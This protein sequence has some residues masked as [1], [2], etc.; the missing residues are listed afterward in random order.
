MQ[1]ARPRLQIIPSAAMG[2]LLTGEQHSDTSKAA[3]DPRTSAQLQ[4]VKNNPDLN[5]DFHG[6]G[7]CESTLA[8]AERLSMGTELA[9]QLGWSRK[10]IHG[11]RACESTWLEQKDHPWVQSCILTAYVED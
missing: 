2:T 7:A 4:L 3:T 10:T 11:Y 9:C 6:Y 8:G 5:R 1:W